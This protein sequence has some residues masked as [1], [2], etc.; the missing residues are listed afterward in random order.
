M[1]YLRILI[2][3]ALVFYITGAIAQMTE[4]YYPRLPSAD[5]QNM[6][7]VKSEMLQILKKVYLMW[8]NNGSKSIDG[9]YLKGISVLDERIELKYKGDKQLIIMYFSELGLN[10]IHFWSGVSVSGINRKYIQINSEMGIF[11]FSEKDSLDAKNFADDLF[12]IQQPFKVKYKIKQ[13]SLLAAFKL[14]AEKYHASKVKPKIS[15][16][17]RKYIIQA[18]GFNDQKMYDKAIELYKKAIEVD[19]TAYPAAYSNLALLSAQIK[20]FNEAIY[21]MKKYLMLEPEA[22]DGRSAQDKIY[23]WEAQIKN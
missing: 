16:E 20:R 13:D 21:Y 5:K 9:L 1:K 23:L 8:P 22:S 11:M 12:F 10:P 18:N 3:L 7:K 19:Q 4:T 14:I 6:M 17:Q 15:E 2:L